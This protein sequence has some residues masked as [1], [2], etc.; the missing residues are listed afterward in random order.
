MFYILDV[1]PV[2]KYLQLKESFLII[3]RG[4]QSNV[5]LHKSKLSL[6]LMKSAMRNI[7]VH[8]VNLHQNLHQIFNAI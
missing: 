1:F 4:D 5:D 3:V 8:Y 7:L 6:V 2:R